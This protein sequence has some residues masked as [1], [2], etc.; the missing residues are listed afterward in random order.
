[1]HQVRPELADHQERE[2]RRVLRRLDRRPEVPGRH[3]GFRRE[4][5]VPAAEA[6]RVDAVQGRLR[7]GRFPEE[8]GAVRA[9]GDRVPRRQLHQ[10]ARLA[11][12]DEEERAERAP[13]HETVR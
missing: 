7:G 13:R 4:R 10:G 2:V 11:H 12:A 1:M 3:G 6:E 9:E 5:Q 8:S